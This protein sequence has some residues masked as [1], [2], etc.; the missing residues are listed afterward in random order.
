MQVLSTV[1]EIM[2]RGKGIPAFD[3]L[4]KHF[5]SDYEFE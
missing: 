1:E 5:P 4:R 2:N 3:A